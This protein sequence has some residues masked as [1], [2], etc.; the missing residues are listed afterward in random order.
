MSPSRRRNRGLPEPGAG[1]ERQR[2]QSVVVHGPLRFQQLLALLSRTF[3]RKPVSRSLPQHNVARMPAQLP[4][5]EKDTDTVCRPHPGCSCRASP[6]AAAATTRHQRFP[7]TINLGRPLSGFS[8]A[9]HRFRQSPPTVFK[10]RQQCLPSRHRARLAGRERAFPRTCLE[11]D[12]EKPK[13]K[14]ETVSVL[15]FST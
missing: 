13:Q 8:V 6:P 9:T 12:P 5:S 11:P 4:L 10:A 1:F 2:F 15:Q 14:I 3:C 7:A